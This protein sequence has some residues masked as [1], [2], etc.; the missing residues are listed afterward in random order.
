[1]TSSLSMDWRGWRASSPRS[2]MPS[3]PGGRGSRRGNM[4][5]SAL[6][7]T[8]YFVSDS[9]ATKPIWFDRGVEL[10]PEDW[11]EKRNGISHD[12]RPG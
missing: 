7:C 12:P 5:C 9:N 10:E 1:V 11:W 8:E 3:E 4:P 2:A 6:S